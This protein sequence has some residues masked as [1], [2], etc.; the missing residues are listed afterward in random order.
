M[1]RHVQLMGFRSQTFPL[2]GCLEP[3]SSWLPLEG[4]SWNVQAILTSFLF[5]A[6]NLS[7][8]C[9]RPTSSCVNP[10]PKCYEI[11]IFFLQFCL[12]KQSYG[13][14]ANRFSDCPCIHVCVALHLYLL[15]IILCLTSFCSRLPSSC[16]NCKEKST[17]FFFS[18]W[19]AE[20]T[21][22]SLSLTL[23]M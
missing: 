19:D 16:R 4:I 3:R 1:E 18:S 11:T 2:A 17:V 7:W 10:P 13:L 23:P 6:I 15:K 21:Y 12:P 22:I 20:E 9:T 5:L 14:F 8:L